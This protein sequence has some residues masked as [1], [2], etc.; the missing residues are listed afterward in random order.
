MNQSRRE[1]LTALSTSALALGV[2]GSVF[3]LLTSGQ[4]SAAT[5]TKKGVVN[6]E[7]LS[8]KS[9]EDLLHTKFK[10]SGEGAADVAMELAEVKANGHDPAMESFSVTFLGPK[11]PALPQKIYHFEHAKA[12]SFDLFIVPVGQTETGMHY[13]AV[14]NRF[15]DKR[16]VSPPVK[17]AKND[18]DLTSPAKKA[19]S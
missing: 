1:F 4:A 13:E 2:P 3:G 8:Q 6:L 11:A 17:T 10:V 19:T 7:D 5:S 18:K 14:F 12:G 16:K 15:K 9:F